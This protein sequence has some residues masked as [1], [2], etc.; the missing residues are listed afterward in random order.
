GIRDDLVTGV[1]TCALPISGCR[2]ERQLQLQI[3]WRLFGGFPQLRQSQIEIGPGAPPNGDAQIKLCSRVQRISPH[4]YNE[5]LFSLQ[6]IIL[7]QQKTAQSYMFRSR[8]RLLQYHELVFLYSLI[9]I[10]ETGLDCSKDSVGIA[11]V[12]FDFE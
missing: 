5:S 8:G 4:S 3:V 6:K 2:G 7:L 12:R 11:I 10:A 9:N 1:Q